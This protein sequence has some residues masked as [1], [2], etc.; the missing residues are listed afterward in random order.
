MKELILNNNFD[1]IEYI[2]ENGVMY[3]PVESIALLGDANEETV[4]RNCK[5]VLEEYIEYSDFSTNMWKSLYIEK[6]TGGR[7]K[8]IL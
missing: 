8:K 7:P 5:E 2:I 4:R 3:L 1:G 6:S